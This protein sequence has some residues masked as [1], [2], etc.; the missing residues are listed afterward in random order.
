MSAT[1]DYSTRHI[2]RD[3]HFIEVDSICH[4]RI[5]PTRVGGIG[6]G[7]CP[8]NKGRVNMLGIKMIRHFDDPDYIK[9]NHPEAKD[10]E[11]SGE[12]VWHWNQWFEDMALTHMYD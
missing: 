2:K 8:F 1:Y 6:C 9:C 12:V 3:F 7:M 5:T 11:N 10:S 4:N